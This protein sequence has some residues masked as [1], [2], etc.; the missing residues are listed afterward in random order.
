MDNYLG[1]IRTFA[2]GIVPR[3]WHLCDGTLLN[4]QQNMALYSLIGT[5]FGGDGKT[6]FALPDLRGRAIVASNII[7]NSDYKQ[8]KA[9][10]SESVALTNA[11]TNHIHYMHVENAPGNTPIPTN[12]L[13]IPDVAAIQSEV[14][15]IYSMPVSTPSVSLN[16]ETIAMQGSSAGH[17]NMQPFL[18]LNYCIA[19]SGVYPPRPY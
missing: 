8:G 1:E 7:P 13:A 10:G 6:T 5:T 4:M 9:G 14:I 18:V 15:N 19:T 11:Q 12:I 16:A 3:G 17:N 2:F